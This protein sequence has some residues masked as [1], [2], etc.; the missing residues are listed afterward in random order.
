[1]LRKA[2]WGSGTHKILV[3]SQELGVLKPPKSFPQSCFGVCP[4]Q[5][6]NL[7]SLLAGDKN[8]MAFVL[9]YQAFASG[10]Q[11]GEEEADHLGNSPLFLPSHGP[12]FYLPTYQESV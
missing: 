3:S 10:S 5:G 1:M 9:S 6:L 4:E 7:L 8:Y 2:E 11:E 12:S